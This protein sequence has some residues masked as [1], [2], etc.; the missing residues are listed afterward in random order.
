MP[1]EYGLVHGAFN[2]AWCW[3]LMAGRLRAEGRRVGVRPFGLDC[4]H[5]P[6]LSQ[7]DDVARILEAV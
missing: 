7:P 5:S 1:N 4:A 6:N 2:G 3:D